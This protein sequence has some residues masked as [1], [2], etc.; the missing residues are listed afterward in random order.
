L[1]PQAL[2]ARILSQSPSPTKQQQEAIF[3]PEL[4]YF[5]RAAPGSGKTWTACRRFIWRAACWPYAVGGIALLSFTNVAIR[6]FQDA[7]AKLGQA[8]LFRD[9]NYLGTFDSFVERFVLGP[10]GH[11]LSGARTR[12][13]LH[14]TVRPGDR[15][16]ASL[17][18]WIATKDGKRPVYAWDIV[19]AIEA[20]KLVFRTSQEYGGKP[21][22][23]GKANSATTALLKLGFYTHGQRAYWA[24]RLLTERPH[25]AARL[26]TR[27][28]EIIVDEAQDTNVWL[29][30][31]LDKL[32]QKGTRVTLAGD[33]DQCIYS[34]AMADA[35]SLLALP[36][37]WHIPVKPLDKSFRCNDQIATAVK[38]MGT[39]ADFEGRG[40]SGGQHKRP[41]IFRGT[42]DDDFSD[43]ISAFRDLLGVAG[44]PERASAI[45]CRANGHLQSVR[46][47]VNYANLTGATKRLAEGAFYRD[48]RKDY[49]E[50]FDR[51]EEVLR[52]LIWNA[53][54]WADFDDSPDSAEA[55]K[56]RETVWKFVKSKEGL[57]PVSLSGDVWVAA[58]KDR[59]AALI[60]SLGA[61]PV[62]TLGQK[63][64]KRGLKQH[65]F[66]LPLFEEQKLF[67]NIRHETIH[68]VKG[69]S[70]GAVLVIGSSKFWNSVVTA[71]QSGINS[72][73][74]RLA[75]VAM[76]RAKDLLVLSLPS[77]H[78]DKH[79]ERWRGWGFETTATEPLQQGSRKSK[80]R[81]SA[82]GR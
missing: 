78:Y 38:N 36:D 10:F 19:P 3:G 1:E 74:R 31:L 51:V 75:Y 64:Q 12:P 11:L 33:P 82:A 20:D 4:A 72:E 47:Q 81:R 73:D 9:P 45:I 40:D 66:L 39:N 24:N 71:V 52:E 2:R 65:Q 42:D 13:K 80:V 58:M 61:S 43:S 17:Q 79:V 55:E 21:L 7:A 46:G 35:T 29:L 6:E 30:R 77:S 54:T 32:R 60:A 50:A 44:I 70:I 37:K 18:C 5:L 48:C 57:P 25:I 49:K 62:P 22:D 41:F 69:E 16:N 76:T 63:I 53:K 67:P 8:Q 23:I 26:A 15:K 59:M 68:Q 34:F 56:F 14:R 28:P 27:F